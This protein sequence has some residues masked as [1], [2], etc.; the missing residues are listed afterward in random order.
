MRFHHDDEQQRIRP[1]PPRARRVPAASHPERC[2]RAFSPDPLIG[3]LGRLASGATPPSG[4]PSDWG[5]GLH[6][7]DFATGV[8]LS[9]TF[10]A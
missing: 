7:F 5:H 10:H 8:Q 1:Q 6:R 4:E 9:Y 3:R 2:C